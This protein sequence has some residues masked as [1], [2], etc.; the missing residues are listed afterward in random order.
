MSSF[1]REYKNDNMRKF[2]DKVY[3]GSEFSGK[4]S[5]N[6]IVIQQFKMN[7]CHFLIIR[8]NLMS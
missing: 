7:L 4:F 1:Q 6:L 8:L 5:D 2:P 3:M